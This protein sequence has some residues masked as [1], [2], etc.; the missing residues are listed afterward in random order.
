MSSSYPHSHRIFVLDTNVLIH[1]PSSIFNFDEHDVAIPMTVLEE[2]DHIKDSQKGHHQQIGRD[3]RLAIQ[4][5]EQVVNGHAPDALK[6]GV[7]LG[8]KLGNLRVVMESKSA[9]GEGL[10]LSVPD[11]RIINCALQLNGD[12]KSSS[13]VLV[14]KDINM[15]LKA[16]AAGV[17]FVEDYRTDQ[18]LSDINYLSAG[19]TYVDNDWLVDVESCIQSGNKN[20]LTVRK[21]HLPEKV[22]ANLFPNFAFIQGEEGSVDGTVWFVREVH[23]ET[24][25]FSSK[26]MKNLMS[27]RAFG[28][29]PINPQQALAMDALL[30][31]DI[32]IVFL[33]GPAGT[34]KTLLAL[35][36]AFE[37]SIEHN[38]FD[39]IIVTRSVTDMDESIGYLP[40]SEEEKM[41]PW[42]GAFTD[43]MEVLAKDTAKDKSFAAH[44]QNG[45]P[46]GHEAWKTTME[47]LMEKANLQFKS[48]NFM[49]GRSIQNACVILDESQNLTAHQMQSLITRIGTGSKLIVMGN[50]AQIDA[51]YLTALSSGLT[52]G[53]EKFKTFERGATIMLKGGVRSPVASFAEENF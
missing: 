4:H 27:K 6:R 47:M 24:V 43:S 46:S 22:K 49:R 33:T 19:Y 5:I 30:A 32:D 29:T 23:D 41:L 40:G 15:R 37:L 38:M 36:V 11:N 1:D 35:A 51:R 21:E 14:T 16:R 34:G 20:M 12:S 13:I 7:P 25:V 44:P 48:V 52:V 10:D 45:K 42:L 9:F 50:L 2:L 39:K 8:D 31:D 26:S 3:A 28:I 18:I 17:E 53:V